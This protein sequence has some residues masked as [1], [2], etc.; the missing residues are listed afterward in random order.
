MCSTNSTVPQFFDLSCL[1][2]TPQSGTQIGG[3]IHDLFRYSL[4]QKLKY[5][6]VRLLAEDGQVVI[7]RLAG[8]KSRYSGQILI[9][10]DGRY[11]HNLYFGRIDLDGVFYE[12]RTGTSTVKELIERFASN[13][14]EVAFTYGQLSGHCCFCDALL[15]DAR[16][17]AHGYGRDCARNWGLPWDANRKARGLQDSLYIELLIAKREYEL[18]VMR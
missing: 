16:S 8:S 3:E 11:P 4:S 17:L 9:V 1:D 13:P 6:R 12:S 2:T 15:S 7:L 5:P 18:K 10:D 14:R